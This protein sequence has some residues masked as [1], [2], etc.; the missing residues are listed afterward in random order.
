LPVVLE[1]M[2]KIVST[3]DPLVLQYIGEFVVMVLA[4]SG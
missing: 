3:A 1:A 4:C 2:E